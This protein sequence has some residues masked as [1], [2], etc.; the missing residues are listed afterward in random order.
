MKTILKDGLTTTII[1]NDEDPSI[2]EMRKFVGG[3]IGHFYWHDSVVVF[4]DDG[5]LKNYNY[6][7]QASSIV[8]VGLVGNVGIIAVKNFLPEKENIQW[9]N[10]IG[11]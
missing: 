9:K 6:N 1:Y 10:I 8:G 11:Q 7:L 4:D 5:R 3:D 2:E